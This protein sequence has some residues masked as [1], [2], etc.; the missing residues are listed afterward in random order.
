M[1]VDDDKVSSAVLPRVRRLI[2]AHAAGAL[3]GDEMPEDALLPLQLAGES[4]LRALTLPMALNYQRNSYALWPAVAALWTDVDA[5]WA[6]N[7]RRA[8]G[9]SVDDLRRVLVAHRVALQPVRH[10][11]TW[12]RIVETLDVHFDGRVDVLLDRAD[13][14]VSKLRGLVQGQHKRGFPYLSGPKIFNYWSYV[15]MSYAG[16]EWVD[17][18][19]ITVAP[20]TH[21]IQASHRLGL[22]GPDSAPSVVAAAWD[23]L[24]AD[25]GIAPIDVHTPLWLWSR[26][27]FPNVEND[28]TAESA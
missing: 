22:T 18:G 25:T 8:S 12:R 14:S 6:L 15:L 5:R 20:D 10:I 28:P 16:I 19:L 4:L 1:S 24:L 21:V 3:G 23:A 9:A 11:Q 26:A 17:R 2:D 13:H 7:P 27:G